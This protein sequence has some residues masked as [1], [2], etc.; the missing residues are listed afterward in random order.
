MFVVQVTLTEKITQRQF[1]SLS[2]FSPTMPH[3]NLLMAF[4]GLTITNSSWFRK[5]T[6]VPVQVPTVIFE[7]GQ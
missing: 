7:L 1:H 4:G 5:S 3:H 2:A 6:D